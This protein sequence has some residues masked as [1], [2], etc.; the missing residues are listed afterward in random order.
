MFVSGAMRHKM[1][2]GQISV[3]V[4]VKNGANTIGA[5]LEALANQVEAP[6]FEI[7]VSDNGSRDNLIDILDEAKAQWPH[8]KLTRIDS[9][10]KAGV[11]YAR[12]RGIAVASSSLIA[13]CDCDDVVSSGWVRAM[14]QGLQSFDGVGGALDERRLNPGC[15]HSQSHAE[16][17]LPVG[18]NFLPYPIG[19]NIG[20]RREVWG[21]LNGFDESYAA[22]AEEV[23]FFW[24]LQLA[25]FSLGFL[26][27]AI[28]YYRQRTG[29]IANARHAFGR[30]ISSCQ[31]F[32]NFKAHVPRESL[33][34]ILRAW[35]GTVARLP[36]LLVP[37][38][39]LSVVRRSAH[40]VGQVVGS[41]RFRVIHLA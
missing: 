5:Q 14:H 31:L 41:F 38:M 32:A 17:G 40:Q 2:Y 24:R 19:A 39:R 1:S 8:L 15:N 20:L 28:V 12:N 9:S 6:P 27:E 33:P 18:L 3:V 37:S 34:S 30:G 25:G 7:V 13:V 10:G 29:I 21:S 11:A 22:G 4:P 23:D 16:S 36:L 26:P 35:G